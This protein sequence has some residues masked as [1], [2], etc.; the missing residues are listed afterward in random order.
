MLYVQDCM[1]TQPASVKP[2]ASLKQAVDLMISRRVQG[3]AVV[4][5]ENDFLG[6][7]TLGYLLR[8]FMPEH[9]TQLSDSYQEEVEEVS[10][11]AFFGSTSGLFLVTDF[12]TEEV[13]PLSPGDSLLKAA[14]EMHRQGYTVLPVVIKG[15][16]A[17]V[18]TQSNIMQALFNRSV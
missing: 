18:L 17:G 4:D 9:L 10:I 16:L 12:F 11:K 14:M 2:S 5:E 13:E 8:G 15:K 7:L 3:L 6:L 1:E